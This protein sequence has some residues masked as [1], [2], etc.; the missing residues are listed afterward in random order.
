MLRYTY[1]SRLVQLHFQ[2]CTIY[3]DIDTGTIHVQNKESNWID[4]YYIRYLGHTS[5]DDEANLI[6]VLTGPLQTLHTQS[7][8]LRLNKLYRT[9]RCCDYSIKYKKNDF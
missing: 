2:L 1:I 3:C 4:L 7:A 5:K 9:L 6:L 8:F